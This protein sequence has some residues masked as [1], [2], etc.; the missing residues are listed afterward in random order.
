MF[1]GGLL[2]TGYGVWGRCAAGEFR[3]RTGA[4]L[5]AQGAERLEAIR[6]DAEGL[7]GLEKAC[8]HRFAVVGAAVDLV[9]EL[10]REGEAGD[11]HRHAGKMP[12]A[13]AH[14]GQRLAAHVD[15]VERGGEHVAALGPRSEE[16]TSELQSLMR[17]SYAVFCLKKNTQNP[18][19]QQ[20][21]YDIRTPDTKM[22]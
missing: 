4:L 18:L 5:D 11:Q 13:H 17:I 22:K 19:K 21:F 14:E 7:A 3:A 2:C 8:P 15:V 10:A 9:G 1:F 16:H 12:L 20:A 6:N